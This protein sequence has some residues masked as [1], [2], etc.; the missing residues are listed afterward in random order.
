MR[1]TVG[2]TAVVGVAMAIVAAALIVLVGR[3]LS[4]NVTR[5]ALLRANDVAAALADGGTAASLTGDA[6]DDVIQ[7][8]D[9]EG[10]VVA[11]SANVEGEPP[12]AILAP[13]RST[14]VDPAPVG[15]GEAFRV[16]AVAAATRDGQVTVL[17]GRS[18]EVLKESTEVLMRILPV[19]VALVLGVVAG[20]TWLVVGRALGP[21]EAIRSEV[22]DISAAE[23]H[24]RVP[25]PRGE[26][27]IAR[28]SRTMNAMLGRLEDSHRRQQRFISD[29]SH[30][31]RSPAATIR[32]VAELALAHPELASVPELADDVLAEDLRIQRLVEDLLI[33]ARADEEALHTHHEPVDV[34]DLVFEAADRLRDTTALTID[35]TGV[36]A[37]Q[38]EGDRRQLEQIVQNLVENAARH[39]ASRIGVTLHQDSVAVHLRIDDDGPGIPAADRDRVFERFTRLDESRTRGEGGAGLGLAIVA[40][41]VAVHEGS[42]QVADAPAGGARFDVNFPI[43]ARSG[44][45]QHAPGIA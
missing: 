25:E 31:L 14:T 32:H 4:A 8:I 29:A 13:G 37:G 28:L 10:R 35:T 40:E 3:S 26:D 17:V 45:S 27:E 12:L 36:S 33:L 34:D 5:T 18:L 6:E 44:E 41:L 21:V 20:T 39:A 7:V 1:T 43:G 2:A 16:V 23:L 15:D 19:G 11:S 38:I 9:A 42:I 22:A 24:R 30:E